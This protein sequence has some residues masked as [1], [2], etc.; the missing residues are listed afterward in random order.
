VFD[1]LIFL[2]KTSTKT[3]PKPLSQNGVLK[4]LNAAVAF[5]RCDV[6]VLMLCP[7]AF[8]FTRFTT[9]LLIVERW[10]IIYPIIALLRNVIFRAF[11]VATALI[12]IRADFF[13]H[14]IEF[15]T[16]ACKKR[17]QRLN[18]TNQYGVLKKV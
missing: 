11:M 4:N 10:W 17:N 6:V 18:S 8:G 16:V 13:I 15:R 3:R 1:I 2:V 12:I 9:F 14:K 7:V 5:T